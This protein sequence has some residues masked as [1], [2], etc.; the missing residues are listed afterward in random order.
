MVVAGRISLS[1]SLPPFPSPFDAVQ[2]ES[3]VEFSIK[4]L[5][6][7]RITF[8]FGEIISYWGLITRLFCERHGNNAPATPAR[9]VQ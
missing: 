9:T 1:Q 7:K 4:V 5:N 3:R 8:I 6:T 2:Y